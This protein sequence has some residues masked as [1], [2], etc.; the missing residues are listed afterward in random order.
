MRTVRVRVAPSPTGF[1]HLGL[2]RTALF[3]YLV[4]KQSGGTFV[5]RIEDTDQARLVPGATEYIVDAL[6]WIGITPDEGVC[7][8]E[9]GSL[10]EKG[11]YGPYTQSQRLSLYKQYAEQLLAQGDAYYCFATAEELEAM[12]AEQQQRGEL[13]R[14]DGRYRDLPLEEAQA[15]VAA[16]EPYVIRHKVPAG[17][18]VLFTD[19]IRGDISFSSDTLEDY[20]LMKSDG[21]PTYQLANVVDDHLMEISHVLRGDEWIPS[22]PKNLLLYEAFGWEPPLFAHLPVILGPDGKK[23]LSKRDGAEPVLTYKDEG[24]LP[25][26]IVNFLAFLGWSPGDERERFTLEELVQEFKLEKVQ[27]AG[28]VYNQERLQHLNG[29]YIRSL[30]ASELYHR[31]QPYLNWAE[32][33][34]PRADMS[35][36]QY[37]EA[38]LAAVRDRARTL[39]EMPELVNFCYT[40]PSID[41]AYC[42]LV[43]SKAGGDW[44]VVQQRLAAVVTVL[45]AIEEWTDEVLHDQVSTHIA[46]AGLK[47]GEVLWPIRAALTGVAGSPGAYE[48]LVLLGRQESLERL[49]AAVQQ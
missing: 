47:N 1:P 36:V 46:T 39:S 33:H 13:P 48:M 34:S 15:R 30:S 17:R 20:V 45:E 26:A 7:R 38:V 31:C 29:A 19:V 24:Y 9:D 6:S 37:A 14:Y 43:A 32:L 10:G 21:F 8:L 40:R 23:K 16:G 44:Q 28:A 35:D 49:Q 27:K 11:A 5:L 4:A 12:R 18:T 3:D 22:T 25:E 41:D 42:N 2:I